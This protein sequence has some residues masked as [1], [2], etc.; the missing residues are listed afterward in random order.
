MAA[1]RKR[2]MAGAG[3]G[4]WQRKLGFGNCGE[5]RAPAFG[6]VQS[7]FVCTIASLMIGPFVDK[8]GRPFCALLNLVDLTSGDAAQVRL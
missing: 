1:G 5:S 6:P 8:D 3:A 7:P 2:I 4:L